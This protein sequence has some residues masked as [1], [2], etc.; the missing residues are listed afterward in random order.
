MGAT[1]VVLVTPSVFPE[2]TL[3][4]LGPQRDSPKIELL[5]QDVLLF[6]ILATPL[7]REARFCVNHAV[8]PVP[9]VFF[10]GHKGGGL[11]D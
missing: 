2:K 11:S 8:A 5:A 9:W 3:T 6:F 7:G 1:L 4:A 10:R